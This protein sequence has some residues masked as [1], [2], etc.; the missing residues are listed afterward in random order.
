[1]V[2]V[3]DALISNFLKALSLQITDCVYDAGL[4]IVLNTL[5]ALFQVHVH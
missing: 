4:Y 3:I 2:S 5:D 1:M